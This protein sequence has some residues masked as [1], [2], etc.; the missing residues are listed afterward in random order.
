LSEQKIVADDSQEASLCESEPTKS[1]EKS[2]GSSAHNFD[3]SQTHSPPA[4]VTSP[5]NRKTKRQTNEED[6]STSKLAESAAEEPSHGQP[7][8]FEPFDA[9]IGLS[10]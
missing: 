6:S 7:L 8:A 4:S 2:A 1:D 10:F 3:S 5:D 9:A